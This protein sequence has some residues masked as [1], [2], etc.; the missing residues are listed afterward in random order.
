MAESTHHK[1][2]QIVSNEFSWVTA[3][4]IKGPPRWHPIPQRSSG[5]RHGT[6]RTSRGLGAEAQVPRRRSSARGP[7]GCFR[8]HGPSPSNGTEIA[9]CLNFWNLPVRSVIAPTRRL[10]FVGGEKRSSIEAPGCPT[11][12]PSRCCRVARNHAFPPQSFK[13]G[14]VW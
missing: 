1:N 13:Y 5:H 2:L 10:P 14:D 12:C 9:V 4:V 6:G 11:C 3:K 8:P 7:Q